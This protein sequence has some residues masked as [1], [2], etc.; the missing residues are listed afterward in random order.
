MHAASFQRSNLQN[1]PIREEVEEE[2][3]NYKVRANRGKDNYDQ[4]FVQVDLDGLEGDEIA[5]K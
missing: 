1:Q 2:D 4:D 3:V 5:D